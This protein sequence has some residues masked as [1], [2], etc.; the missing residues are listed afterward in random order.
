MK[1]SKVSIR[2]ANSQDYSNI[3]D[4]I[5]SVAAEGLWLAT[6]SYVPT[7]QWERALREP[8]KNPRY[9]IL[10]AGIE[11]QIVGWCRLFPYELGNKSA[12]VS[13]MAI[14][15][16]KDFRGLGIGRTLIEHA[17]EWAK[18]QNYEKVT[19]DVYSSNQHALSLYKKMGF[20][21]TGVRYRQV[22]LRYEY[23]DEVLMEI[24][25]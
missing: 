21:V 5:N 9:L 15:I 7:S 3:V 14:G 17:L 2:R 24:Q 13:D 12:H 16:C 18:A 23:A 8:E 11:D 6:D 22:K 1:E 10:V 20:Q 25:L 19:L 4:L